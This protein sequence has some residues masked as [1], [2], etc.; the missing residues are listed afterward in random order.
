MRL[1]VLMSVVVG[2][3][4]GSASGY[5]ASRWSTQPVTIMGDTV[6]KITS[7]DEN[8][9]I[10]V[11]ERTSSAVVS[12]VVTKDLPKVRSGALDQ[13]D[14]FGNPFR[15]NVPEETGETEPT[16]V[17]GGTGFIVSK[18]GLIVTNKH[19]VSDE[20]AEYTVITKDGKEFEAKVVAID[21][22]DDVALLKIEG[23]DL[24]ALQ[25]GSTED[26]K[27]GQTVIAIGNALGEFSNTVSVG[28][29]SGFGSPSRCSQWT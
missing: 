8:A 20:D 18:D 3:V 9:I 4:F 10:G 1:A 23:K 13:F 27:V 7:S 26:V 11:V 21:P 6:Q 19:V 5:L 22:F 16:E 17:G 29:V 14:F 15:S 25:F 28:V 12:V 2:I 24:T